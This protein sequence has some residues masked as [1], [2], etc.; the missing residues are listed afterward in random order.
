MI[1]PLACAASI[2]NRLTD[3]RPASGSPCSSE[4]FMPHSSQSAHN[5]MTMTPAMVMLF[6]FCCGAIVA[7]IYYAQP[8][9][10]LIAPD[11]GLSS[12]AASLIV[13]LTQI[14]Y[15][16]GLFFLVPLG[17]LLENRRLML[18]TTVVAILSL[19]GAAF[20]EQPNVFLL[21]SLLVGFSSVSVQMLIPLA[22]HLAPEASR[23]R[24]VGGIMGG[25]L[26][27]I[28]LARPIAS[29]VADHFGW[30]A[31]F[32]SAAV[33][34]IGISVVLA[35]TMPKRL[36]DHRASYGQLLFSL[37]TLLRTQPVLRQRAFYQACMFATFSLFWTAVPLELSRNHGLS[38]T[39]IALFALIGAIGAIAAP[40][41]GRLAD[42][43]YT[44]IASLGALLF[45]ALSFLPGLVH[46]AYSVI[47]LAITGVVLDFCVQTS[48][49]L[50]Q[51][52]VYALDA[53]SRSRLNALYMTSIFIGGAIG[54]AVA[55]PLFDHGGWTWVL[56]AGTALPL[57][58]LLALLRDRSR[59]NA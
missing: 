35:T 49:V 34:M 41:S 21:V 58:A 45:G 20:A 31:V 51:R 11:I 50:G 3:T 8:I 59:Q 32:G 37:W 12:T 47:G 36:P 56:I 26:L 9:I 57:I 40:I 48:M 15:A 33:V 44:R 43:G 19:L 17:D 27:G 38:Q 46:P 29:L 5:A 55:S 54:S 2:K 18:V 39:Q 28:L 30:R 16:L 22:A 42:A 52:T 6:A 14:G 53:A 1:K 10:E 24:V 13:S 4:T 25:L 7:N 23:G